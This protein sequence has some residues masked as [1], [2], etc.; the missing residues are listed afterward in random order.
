MIVCL[1]RTRAAL[2]QSS[3]G[4]RHSF[5]SRSPVDCNAASGADRLAAIAGRPASNGQQPSP[6]GES[7]APAPRGRRAIV[8]GAAGVE[9]WCSPNALNGRLQQLRTCN[10]TERLCNRWCR[11]LRWS[12][13]TRHS[14][15]E[16]AG[17]H[18]RLPLVARIARSSPISAA[19]RLRHRVPASRRRPFVAERCRVAHTLQHSFIQAREPH[20]SRGSSALTF[21]AHRAAECTAI[22][23]KLPATAS[24]QVSR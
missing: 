19:R 11:P 16:P 13:Q 22:A 21:V 10:S 2:R 20:R 15:I 7:L 8:G 3:T 5:D 14:S 12:S 17:E 4:L 1:R 9:L 23:V 6:D 24:R 18:P